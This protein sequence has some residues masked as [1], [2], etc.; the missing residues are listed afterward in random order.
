[1][2]RGAGSHDPGSV[3]NWSVLLVP[4]CQTVD[5]PPGDDGSRQ[6]VEEEA[7]F[8]PRTLRSRQELNP[9]SLSLHNRTSVWM[10]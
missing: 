4:E 3:D 1:M 10:S 9:K 7:R 5:T 6:S 8:I 2:I